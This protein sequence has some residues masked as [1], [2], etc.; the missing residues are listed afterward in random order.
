MGFGDS[1]HDSSFLS[2]HG[3]C[4]SFDSRADG[5]GRGEGVAAVVLKSL[6]QALRDGD[7]IRAVI[8]GSGVIQ[9]GRT[10]GITMPSCEAQVKMIRKVYEQTN[11]NPIDTTYVEGHGMRWS[12]SMVFY[13]LIHLQELEPLQ[14]TRSKPVH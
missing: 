8:R 11:L 1:A 2:S 5:F 14:A 9:D 12:D 13:M 7:A 6:D 4:Y 10:P 3:R